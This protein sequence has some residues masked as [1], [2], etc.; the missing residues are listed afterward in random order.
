MKVKGIGEF[1]LIEELKRLLPSPPQQLVLGVGDDA[2]IWRTRSRMQIATTDTLVQNVHFKANKAT[3]YEVG[4]KAIAVNLS[5]IAAMGGIPRYALITIGLPP[6][7]SVEDVL[8]MYRGMVQIATRFETTLA[9]GDTVSSP[10]ST[11]VTVAVI[12]DTLA[13]PGDGSYLTRSSCKPKDLICVTGTLGASAAGLHMLLSDLALPTEN[14]EVLRAAHLHPVPRVREGQVL[15]A[16]G[17]KAAMDIS[18]GLV[19]DLEKMCAASGVGARLWED[20]IPVHPLVSQHFPGGAL[21]MALYGGEDYELLFAA[22]VDVVDRVAR[23]LNRLRVTPCTVVGEATSENAGRV[24][25]VAKDGSERP[26]A[27]GGYDHFRLSGSSE[28]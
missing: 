10:A 18:D 21:D 16:S 22:P 9:G 5:D 20:K 13:G 6:D 24:V 4:W 15:V 1:G 14:A 3:W 17:V 7:A 26:T 8:E 28:Q 19:G 23:E 27:K 2:A 25:L 11:F 12:G